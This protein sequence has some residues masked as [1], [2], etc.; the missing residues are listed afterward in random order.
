[1]R[2]RNAHIGIAQA[3]RASSRRSTRRT[4]ARCFADARR[5]RPA[6][7]S[8][9][10]NRHASISSSPLFIKVAESTEIFRPM[11]QRGCAQACSG[12]AVR[13]D[14]RRRAQERSARRGQHDLTHALRLIARSALK[15]CVV[16]AVDGQQRCAAA[17]HCIHEQRP[18]HDERFFV[19]E[20]DPLASMSCG[21][22]RRKPAA[23]TIPAMTTSTIRMGGDLGERLF[24][25]STSVD[26]PA[27]FRSARSCAASAAD[28]D[29]DEQWAMSKALFAQTRD[30]ACA[31]SMP[32]LRNV[33]DGARSHQAC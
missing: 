22:C 23:P 11:T 30:V 33:P 18:R 26:T 2:N 4:N 1:M 16:L 32:P 17:L 21:E 13:S 20:Q 5:L 31:H 24:A 15:N 8:R 6:R 10:N 28:V 9:S 27:A 3:A 19:R 12:V 14:S 7:A 25:D 29:D